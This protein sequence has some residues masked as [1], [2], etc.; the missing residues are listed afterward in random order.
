MDPGG[1]RDGGDLRRCEVVVPESSSLSLCPGEGLL[2]NPENV[3]GQL[4][5]F[6]PQEGI[7]IEVEGLEAFLCET[8]ARRERRWACWQGGGR[9][10]GV[11]GTTPSDP[12]VF[13]E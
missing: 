10:E 2:V 7:L 13:R 9:E 6:G 5:L 1:A 4:Y 8:I 3:C 12:K 11:L